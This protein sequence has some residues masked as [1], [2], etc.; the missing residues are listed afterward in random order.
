MTELLSRTF[1]AVSLL[2]SLLSAGCGANVPDIVVPPGEKDAS[3]FLVNRIVGHIKSE[4]GCAIL[5]VI[6]YDRKTYGNNR[7]TKWL[8]TWSAKMSLKLT[9]DEKSTLAPGVSL[10]HLYPNAVNNVGGSNITTGQSFNLGLGGQFSTDATRID[11]SDYSFNLKNDFINKTAEYGDKSPR[12]SP[13][14]GFLVDGDLKIYDVLSSR[15][16]PYITGT[17]DDVPPTT[18]QTDITFIVAGSGNV[19]PTW[20]FVTVSGNT[21]NPLFS[22]GRTSTDDIIITFGPSAPDGKPSQALSE[23]HNIAKTTSGFNTALL[24]HQ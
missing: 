12:C 4:V 13:Y 15:I 3:A 5:K 6:D 16:F 18:L 19:T 8:D 20:K 2:A 14:T 22:S 9:V 17:A 23:A 11:M 10:T 24:G 1:G 21:G 7:R